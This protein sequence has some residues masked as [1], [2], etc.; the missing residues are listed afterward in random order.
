MPPQNL[1]V[2]AALQNAEI[3]LLEPLMAFEIEA[4]DEFMSGI[5]GE[6]NAKLADITDLALLEV[7]DAGLSQFQVTRRLTAM[8]NDLLADLPEERHKALLRYKRRLAQ[9][10]ETLPAEYQTV[11]HTGDRRTEDDAGDSQRL[12]VQDAAIATGV[13]ADAAGERPVS[14]VALGRGPDGAERRLAIAEAVT[15]IAAAAI[16]RIGDIRLSANWMAAAG[17]PGQDG[18]LFDTVR[19][20]GL[21]LCPALG[22][23]I[24]VGK[25]SLSMKTVWRDQDS[26]RRMCAP[27]S[28]IVSAFA[29]V[30]DVHRTLTPQ[31]D[32]A[33]GDSRLLL[34]DLGG[35]R[36]RLG[37]S[38]LAQVFGRFG[39]PVPDLDAPES[40][41]GFFEVIQSLNRDGLAMA[42]RA[43]AELAVAELVGEPRLRLDQ[44]G[45]V[46][47]VGVDPL[48]R[49]LGFGHAVDL[50]HR[51]PGQLPQVADRLRGQGS[52]FSSRPSKFPWSNGWR[53]LSVADRASGLQ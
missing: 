21:E 3:A 40:L 44:E 29:P 24:P 31:I 28:L 48:T 2:V 19:A 22:I 15:N 17:E 8:L 51:G 43:G 50:T 10:I 45:V 25:D 32:M 49:A 14:A 7:V 39:G 1:M 16:G 47:Q 42:Y 33:C 23:A 13:D 36:N 34:I 18:A 6:L 38:C 12:V 37:G 4:P 11:A 30:T 52:S 5:I 53:R 20:V 9:G 41:K 46:G 35:G 27:V 26:E